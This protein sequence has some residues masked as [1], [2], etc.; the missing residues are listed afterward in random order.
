MLENQCLVHWTIQKIDLFR[1]AWGLENKYV[2]KFVY[3]I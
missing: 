2:F 3:I 1:F